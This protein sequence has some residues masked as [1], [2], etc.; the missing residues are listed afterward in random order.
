LQSEKPVDARIPL[1][2][3]RLVARSTRFRIVPFDPVSVDE[4]A[5][6]SSLAQLGWMWTLGGDGGLPLTIGRRRCSDPRP[7]RRR[8]REIARA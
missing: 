4:R 2:L 8:A 1:G 3:R 5:S 6:E 7:N